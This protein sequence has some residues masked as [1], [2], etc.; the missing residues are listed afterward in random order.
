MFTLIDN[1]NKISVFN[2]RIYE[3][4]MKL[5]QQSNKSLFY[6]HI[7]YEFFCYYWIAFI[8]DKFNKFKKFIAFEAKVILWS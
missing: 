4:A 7:N 3:S 2:V 5:K 8:V 6:F 1:E